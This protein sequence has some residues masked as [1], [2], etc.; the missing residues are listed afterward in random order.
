MVYVAYLAPAF[1]MTSLNETLTTLWNYLAIG[2]LYLIFQHLICLLFAHIFKWTFLAALLSG[3]VIGEISLAG[4]VT[5]HLLNLPSWYQEFCPLRWTLSLLLPQVHR[6][7]LMKKL[8]KCKGK[9]IQKQDLPIIVQETCETPTIPPGTLALQEVALDKISEGS[10]IWLGISM[11]LVVILIV[12]V[13]LLI[14]YVTPKRPR[15]APNKP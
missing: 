12:I 10:E 4:G 14:R 13:F 1:A 5:L 8:I 6:E 15:S 9:E 7:D 2:L 3:L 11:A